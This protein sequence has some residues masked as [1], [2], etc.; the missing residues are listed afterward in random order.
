MQLSLEQR[1]AQI[2]DR[3]QIRETIARYAHGL[4]LP[5]R[6]VFASVWA[7]DAVYRVDEPF[8][9]VRGVAA[10]T[11]AWDTFQTIFVSMYHHTMNVVV[12]GPHGDAASAVSFAL[13]TGTDAEGTA[14]TASCI[15]YDTFAR[16][17]GRWLLTERYDKV[18]YMVPWLDPLGLDESKRVYVSPEVIQRLIA[19]GEALGRSPARA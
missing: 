7:P 3:D 14:W 18:N 11:A 2:E 8:G 6:D 15:Y 9:E 19:A 16:I 1:V 10:I 5:D 17:D 13:V 4:D 12:D